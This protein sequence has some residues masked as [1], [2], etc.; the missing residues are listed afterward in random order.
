MVRL[1]VAHGLLDNKLGDFIPSNPPKR[2]LGV[3][4]TRSDAFGIQFNN[5]VIGSDIEN[6]QLGILSLDPPEGGNYF[7]NA[8]CDP[9]N[10]Y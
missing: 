5:E 3:K 4:G 7:H 10:L 1:Q 2:E 8:V 9:M 6:I